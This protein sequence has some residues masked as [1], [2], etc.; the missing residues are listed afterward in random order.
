MDVVGA[1]LGEASIEARSAKQ[2]TSG[3]GD[4]GCMLVKRFE[5]AA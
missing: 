2:P 1:F 5:L 4:L 3:P